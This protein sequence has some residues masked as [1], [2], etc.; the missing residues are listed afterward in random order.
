MRGHFNHPREKL[1]TP[2]IYQPAEGRGAVEREW[3]ATYHARNLLNDRQCLRAGQWR[4][5]WSPGDADPG[6]KADTFCID[7]VFISSQLWGPGRRLNQACF[8]VCF[9]T[10]VPSSHQCCNL[11]TENSSC[12]LLKNNLSL[13]VSFKVAWLILILK[14]TTRGQSRGLCLTPGTHCC[15]AKQHTH[16]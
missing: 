3:V 2:Q 6:C 7:R 12:S 5:C 10:Q 15:S 16:T 8:G 1:A 9:D 4:A 11:V 13:C 14:P